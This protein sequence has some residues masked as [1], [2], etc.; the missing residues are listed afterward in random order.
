MFLLGKKLGE[1]M[2]VR[3]YYLNFSEYELLIPVPLHPK[4]LKKRGF[5][6]AAI[7]A[8]EVSKRHQILLDLFSLCRNR[9]SE[10]QTNLTY[11]ERKDNV[12]DAF[13]VKLSSKIKGK[14][15]LLIDDVYT[16]GATVNECSKVLLRAGAKKVDVLT[17][18]RAI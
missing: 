9:D 16:T 7:L 6:Q 2:A 17:L 13:S 5:N 14:N 12:K 10:S 4:K 3:S 11:R 15:I 18:A 8:K 1:I